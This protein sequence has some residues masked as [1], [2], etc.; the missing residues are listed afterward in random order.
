MSPRLLSVVALL[1]LA[2]TVRAEDRT[3]KVKHLTSDERSQ[4]YAAACDVVF[5]ADGYTTAEEAE[6]IADAR[7]MA[8]RVR[9]EQAAKPMRETQDLNFHFAFV[10]SRESGCPWQAG[11]P[12]RDTACKGHTTA[13]GDFDT[14][15]A[16]G[17]AYAAE[18]APDVDC[19]VTL[20]K[21]LPGSDHWKPKEGRRAAGI[22]V[23]DLPT[24]P[25]DVRPSADIPA[26]GCRV[27]M[28]SIDGQAFIHELGHALF[29]L[30]DEYDEYEGA[31]PDEERWEVAISPNLTLQPSNARWR[32]ILS[33]PPVQGGGY[34]KDGVWR[35]QQ[36]CRM[37]ESRSELFCP[38]CAAHITGAKQAKAPK[39][40]E[41]AS[42][43]EGQLLEIVGGRLSFDATWRHQSEGNRRPVHFSV[44]LRRVNEDGTTRKVWKDD[45]EPNLRKLHLDV[46]LRTP[47]AYELRIKA[48]NLAGSSEVATLG[49]EVV[50]GERAGLVDGVPGE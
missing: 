10:N 13:E 44:E 24:G 20:V 4:D 38:V 23:A 48:T 43:I 18:L 49:L 35:P 16:R 22:D 29:A 46:G 50:A 41:W 31:I 12:P 17:D 25:D 47:G 21:L 37:R 33:T 26:D 6:F 5:V 2:G 36:S 39:A 30:A 40:A 15:A 28:T 45:L 11:R 32:T 27:R 14:D 3:G 7:A 8:R 34:Y 9:V 1:A 42:P 19:V